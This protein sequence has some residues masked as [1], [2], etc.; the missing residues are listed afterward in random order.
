MPETLSSLLSPVTPEDFRAQYFSKKGFYAGGSPNKFKNIFDWE[1]LNRV[2]ETSF[3]VREDIVLSGPDLTRFP[4]LKKQS[5]F[6]DFCINGVT[7]QFSNLDRYSP[8]INKLAEQLAAELQAG[9]RITLFASYPE[10]AG[11]DAHYDGYDGFIIQLGGEKRWQLYEPGISKDLADPV[12]E[13]T[14]E[15][16]QPFNWNQKTHNMEISRYQGAD[17]P[18]GQPAYLDK[19][20]KPGDFLYVPAGHWHR[21]T[22][23]KEITLHLTV[24]VNYSRGMDFFVWLREKL[25][26]SGFFQQFFPLLPKEEW[27]SG[28]SPLLQNY[29]KNFNTEILASLDEKYLLSEY[30]KYLLLE[31]EPAEWFNFPV[32]YMVDAVSDADEKILRKNTSDFFITPEKNNTR[33]T[34]N[35]REIFV[36]KGLEPFIDFIFSVESFTIRDLF[37][38]LR[39]NSF[40]PVLITLNNLIR[41]NIIKITEE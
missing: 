32:H 41:N 4:D 36:E 6:I 33:V 13:F 20:L 30:K 26:N 18:T 35:G 12:T 31:H 21:V 19:V 2:L 25:S 40:R 34:V 5:E 27:Q 7:L 15:E 14:I 8:E 38:N 29:M 39:Y 10:K 11:Y 28:E 16:F 1:A 17:S 3:I 37:V 9:V 23:G 22:P 24:R